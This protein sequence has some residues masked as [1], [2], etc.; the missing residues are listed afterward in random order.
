MTALLEMQPITVNGNFYDLSYIEFVTQRYF[1][2][3]FPIFHSCKGRILASLKGMD[4]TEF[5]Q[6][7]MGRKEKAR[8]IAKPVPPTNSYLCVGDQLKCLGGS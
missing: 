6:H 8:K 7:H 3:S 4:S 1:K 5:C 2:L